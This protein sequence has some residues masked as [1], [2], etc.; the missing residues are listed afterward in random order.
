MASL[1]KGI[2]VLMVAMLAIAAGLLTFA[3]FIFGGGRL[4]WF[5]A[6]RQVAPRYR[7]VVDSKWWLPRM[8]FSWRGESASLRSV[9]RMEGTAL[10]GTLLETIA[11]EL[12]E[13]ISIYT[14]NWPGIS[15]TVEPDV[16]ANT[17][18]ESR[19]VVRG[20]GSDQASIDSNA[21]SGHVRW[22]ISEFGEW[23]GKSCLRIE[24]TPRR[25]RIWIS[26][27]L[28]TAEEL[29][30]FLRLGL[31]IVDQLRTARTEGLDFVNENQATIL[32]DVFCP[33]CTA[34]MEGRMVICVRCKTPHCRDCWE[35]NGKC[36]MFA[37]TETRYAVV[38]RN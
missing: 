24:L 6:W 5:A 36:G 13:Q 38:G 8:R 18:F 27:K 25:I 34:P 3:W 26:G 1:L 29:D 20:T 7:A 16:P 10:A 12:T 23:S 17:G 37:C 21:I 4:R 30:D 33:I 31:R 22:Q 2:L 32:N 35:Y 28:K 15:R 11:P 9:R 19:F 14:L